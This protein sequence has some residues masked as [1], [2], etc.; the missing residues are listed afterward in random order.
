MALFLFGMMSLLNKYYLLYPPKVLDCRY[1]YCEIKNLPVEKKILYKDKLK[2]FSFNEL[3]RPPYNVY[4]LML[5]RNII[6][7]LNFIERIWRKL[8]SVISFSKLEIL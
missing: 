8:V 6:R 5:G 7:T 2:Y 1:N 3:K 4:P